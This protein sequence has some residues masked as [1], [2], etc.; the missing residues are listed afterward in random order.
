ML[1]MA[2]TP[3]SLR[4]GKAPEEG[5]TADVVS[6]PQIPVPVLP[7]ESVSIPALVDSIASHQEKVDSLIAEAKDS[8]DAHPEIAAVAE[9]L[10]D[11]AAAFGATDEAPVDTM[12]PDNQPSAIKTKRDTTQMDSLELAIY[13]YNKVI[14]DSLA[15]DSINKRRQ[16][17]IDSPVEYSA[18][19]SLVYEAGTSRAFLFGSSKVKYQ[20][21]DLASEN[22]SMSLDSNLVYATGKM[23]TVIRW[24]P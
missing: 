6:V 24:I 8:L 5:K 15:R 4:V 18:D 7:A 19:D 11:S 20:N 12:I 9:A 10:A 21:M 1:M 13:K 23:D 3:S 17:G 22:I 14:D 2:C 16:N